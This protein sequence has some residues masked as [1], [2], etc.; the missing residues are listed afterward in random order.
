M[1]AKRATRFAFACGYLVLLT[2]F[3]AAQ[4]T[5]DGKVMDSA[6]KPVGG[7]DVAIYVPGKK[8]PV[9]SQKSNDKTGEYRFSNLQLTGAFDIMYTHSIYETATVS[10]LADHDNQHVSKVIYKKGEPKPLTAVHEQF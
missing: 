4:I 6:N 10:R 9:S 2:S 5:V 7:V 1:S 8:D 3:A